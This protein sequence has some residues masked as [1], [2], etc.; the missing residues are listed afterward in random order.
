MTTVRIFSLDRQGN[1][2]LDGAIKWDGKKVVLDPPDDKFLKSL[3]RERIAIA[4]KKFSF[5]ENPES[6]LRALPLHYRSAYLRAV[7]ES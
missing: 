6:Y 7:L 5:S 4:G 2:H 3:L 1:D